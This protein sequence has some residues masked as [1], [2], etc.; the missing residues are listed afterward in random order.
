MQKISNLLILVSILMLIYSIW[1]LSAFLCSCG[2]FCSAIFYYPRLF[3]NADALMKNFI[4]FIGLV[5]LI[6]GVAILKNRIWGITIARY[7]SALVGLAVLLLLFDAGLN[8][9]KGYHLAGNIS[10]AI[11]IPLLP[12]LL[13]YVLLVFNK[14][15]K[16]KT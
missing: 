13:F 15:H 1:F 3:I 11:A 5:Y 8:L 14:N 9:L 10:K 4:I 16:K 12:T 7:L 6:L 2:K